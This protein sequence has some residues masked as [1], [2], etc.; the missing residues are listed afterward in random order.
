MNSV[1]FDSSSSLRKYQLHFSSSQ[2]NRNQMRSC[3]IRDEA[4]IVQTMQHYQVILQPHCGRFSPLSIQCAK[5]S[6]MTG[7]TEAVVSSDTERNS[8]WSACSRSKTYG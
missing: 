4:L 1:C 5:S 3:N 6:A 7:F 8:L 2:G